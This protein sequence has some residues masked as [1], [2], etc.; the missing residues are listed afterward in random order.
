MWKKESTSIPDE[1]VNWCMEN[2]MN[3]PQK[4]K[5]KTILC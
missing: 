2:N 5:N 1:N 4:I 3:I